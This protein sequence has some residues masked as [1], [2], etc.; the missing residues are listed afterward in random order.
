LKISVIILTLNASVYIDNQLKKLKEQSIVP[1]EILI[2]D[3]S[4]QDNTC[5]IARSHGISP[6]II[7]REE[8]SHAR[9][10]NFAASIAK[11]DILIFFSQ[12]AIPYNNLLI[13]NLIKNLN[14]GSKI[15]AVYGRHIPKQEAK[16]TEIAARYIN[17]PPKPII[18]DL[19]LLPVLGAK[20]FFFS[21]VCS[22]IKKDIFEKLGG[23][24]KN[25]HIA[26]DTI[27]AAYAIKNGYKIIYAPEAMVLHS[28]NYTLWQYCKRYY[29]IAKALSNHKWII[30]N[31]KL[32]KEG[33]KIVK[34]QLKY[35]IK[36]KKMHWLPYVAIENIFKFIGFKIGLM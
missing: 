25:A 22:A 5:D 9:T 1:N 16:P 36:N 27:F 24:Y 35:C 30:E 21:N 33:K 2:I 34:E 23:F 4:S 13:E 26:E 20:T 31:N 17:Y 28:H 8:F 7:P 29:N 3:S 19:N 14:K 32:S 10:R 12:D 6:I 18:K 11:G 15:A